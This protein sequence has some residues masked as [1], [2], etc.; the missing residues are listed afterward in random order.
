MMRRTYLDLSSKHGAAEIRFDGHLDLQTSLAVLLHDG[1]DAEWN[2]DVLRRTV[3]TLHQSSIIIIMSSLHQL[4][5][6]IGGDEGDRT[7]RIEF[8]ET[9]AL[10]EGAVINSDT[11][12]FRPGFY[13]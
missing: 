12:S 2:F 7:I 9:N 1:R 3:P 11:L 6:S 4:E 5:L 8:T 10:V 13:F